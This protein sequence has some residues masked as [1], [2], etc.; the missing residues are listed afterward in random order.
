LLHFNLIGIREFLVAV[1]LLFEDPQVIPDHHNLMKKGFKGDLFGLE[2]W[3]RRMKNHPP[4]VPASC[5][6]VHHGIGSFKPQF[7]NNRVGCLFDDLFDKMGQGQ[8]NIPLK[9]YAKPKDIA[10]LSLFVASDRA[11]CI[12]GVV[13]PMDGGSNPV[14]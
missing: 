1:D 13:I 4:F 10:N 7:T 6:L 5:K 9:R 11:S 2:R 8:A 3:V 14:I 12:T